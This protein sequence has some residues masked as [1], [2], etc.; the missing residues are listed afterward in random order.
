MPANKKINS[1]V[2]C[3]NEFTGRYC[4]EC[5]EKIIEPHEKTISHIFGI[6]INAFTFADS[7][8][9]G[10]VKVI[11]SNPGLLSKKYSEGAH[12]KFFS[13]VSFFFLMNFIYFL[14]PIFQTYNSTLNTQVK[15]TYHSFIAKNMVEKE[16]AERKLSFEEFDKIYA[17][18]S[19]NLAKT[20][21]VT[22]VFF[23]AAALQLLFFRKKKFFVDNLFIS[24]EYYTFNLL[25]NHFI[26]PLIIILL[27]FILQIFSIDIRPYLTDSLFG[28]LIL[29]SSLYF[30]VR[31]INKYYA[32]KKIYVWLA[33][34]LMLGVLIVSIDAYRFILFLV[35]MWMI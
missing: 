10:A 5:G 9:F 26:L 31:G 28:P 27:I 24:F 33:S 1:C 16:L 18:K 29:L 14:F 4:N 19:E 11:I 32:V 3:R 17:P 23:I 15:L 21:I 13:P 2:S 25:I 7:K 35:T 12:K 6:L 30:F 34:I 20:L 8:L 22:N